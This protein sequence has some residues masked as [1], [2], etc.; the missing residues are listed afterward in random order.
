MGKD[1]NQIT[2]NAEK[3]ATFFPLIFGSK[4]H[5]QR[6]LFTQPLDTVF[7]VLQWLERR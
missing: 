1:T 2:E 3:H 6:F 7:T 4:N 5:P